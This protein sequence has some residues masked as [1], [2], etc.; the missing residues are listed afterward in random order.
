MGD[1]SLGAQS[2]TVTTHARHVKR[3]KTHTQAIRPSLAADLKKRFAS[4][5]PAAP[6]FAMPSKY[7]MADMLR[8]DLAAARAAWV[9]EAATDAEREERQRSDF[10]AAVNHEGQRT[11]FYS[12]R[13]GHGTA[14]ADAGVPE[15][16]I[17]SMH[18]ATRITTAR[19][20]HAGRK[21]VARAI[22]AMPDLSFPERQIAMGTNRAEM[23]TSDD[24]LRN[25]T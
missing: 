25:S 3:R 24:C 16:D 1:F 17:A 11:V 22:D 6:A 8:H 9:G 15:K 12:T 19:Y 23:E 4:K 20:L 14:L 5:L 21:S 2:A 7:H 18:D 10:L 13:H